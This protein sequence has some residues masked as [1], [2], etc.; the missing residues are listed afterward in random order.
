MDAGFV[1]AY[2]Q[3]KKVL[4]LKDTHHPC[5]ALLLGSLHVTC[6]YEQ[7]YFSFS[8]SWLTQWVMKQYEFPYPLFITW[9]QLLVAEV[10]ILV[11]GFLSPRVGGVFS[12]FAPLEWDWAIAK[13]VIPLTVVWLL[14]MAT[15]NIC[16]KYTEVT[17]YQVK[18]VYRSWRCKVARALTILWS[19]MFQQ[20]EFPDLQVSFAAKIACFIVFAGF[21][22]GSV[23]EVNFEWIGWFAGVISSVFVAYYNNSIKKSLVFVDNSSWYIGLRTFWQNR[24]LMIYNTTWAIFMFVPILFLFGESVV[25]EEES[26]ALLTPPVFKGNKIMNY[27]WHFRYCVDRSVGLLD[28]YCHFFTNEN[29]FAPH[30][31]HI[32]YC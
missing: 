7:G 25:F 1:K 19:I 8:I 29:D 26:M 20:L 27:Y 12:L 28:Q 22:V 16:L 14:M 21:I 5:G 31:H 24:R 23:G 3:L 17:F 13:K 15:S 4:T 11:L 30:R 32:W 2:V 18:T 9:I 10:F 6:V